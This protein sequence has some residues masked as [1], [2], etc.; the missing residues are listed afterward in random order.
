V[1]ALAKRGRATRQVERRQ[2]DGGLT[3]YLAFRVGS[4][5]YAL[6]VS[7]VREIV[8][9]GTLTPVPRAPNG[10]LGIS[11]FRGRVVTVIDLGGL[12]GV[13]CSVVQPTSGPIRIPRL[14]ILMIDV[15]QETLGYLVDD[16]VQVYRLAPRDVESAT[17]V[18][19]DVG[20][21]VTGI[22]RPQ[23][24]GEVVLLLDPKA[25]LP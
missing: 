6:P 17:T 14:R 20:A 22:A 3:E 9:S 4:S 2:E 24:S 16:V 19:S 7:I 13:A 21:H 8:R 1:R 5:T 23:E 18:G 15:G 10:V 11:S 25:L 12:L